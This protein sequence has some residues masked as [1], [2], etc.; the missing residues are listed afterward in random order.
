M[1]AFHEVT[2]TEIQNTEPDP[3][4]MQS[5]AGHQEAPK[6]VATVKPVKGRRKQRRGRKQAAGRRGKPEELT[7]E[8]CGSW[9]KLAAALKQ[10]NQFIGYSLVVTINYHNALKITVTVTH[11]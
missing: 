2:E 9:R 7:L 10:A 6:E 1:T 5:V 11:K 4:I 3:R 8:D